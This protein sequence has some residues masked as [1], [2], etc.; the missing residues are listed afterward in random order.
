M[1]TLVAK[2]GRVPF[3]MDADVDKLPTSSVLMRFKECILIVQPKHPHILKGQLN[4]GVVTFRFSFHIADVF[5]DDGPKWQNS[6]FC[7]FHPSQN[8]LRELSSSAED[9]LLVNCVLYSNCGFSMLWTVPGAPARQLE[10]EHENIGFLQQRR[11]ILQ[12]DAHSCSAAAAQ[13]ILNLN[14]AGAPFQGRC[15]PDLL[16]FLTKKV[17]S[18]HIM[19]LYIAPHLIKCHGFPQPILCFS[20]LWL[21]IGRKILCL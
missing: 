3:S 11:P 9:S 4:R 14:T 7:S 2:K 17:T 10:V 18:M 8:D 19:I 16:L 1:G 15:F 6:Q 21:Y 12:Y 13:T 20:S 5:F